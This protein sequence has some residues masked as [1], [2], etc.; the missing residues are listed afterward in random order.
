M[1]YDDMKNDVIIWDYML[2]GTSLMQLMFFELYMWGM[3][4]L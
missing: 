4:S 3:T 1:D 2:N